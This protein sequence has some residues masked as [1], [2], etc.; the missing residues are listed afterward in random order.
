M[1]LYS[2]HGNQF[3]PATT[4]KDYADPLDTPFGD[5]IVTDLTR[6]I[7]P[8]GRISRSLDLR[9]VNKVF[10]VATIPEWVVGRFFYDLLGRVV[11]Y[12]LLPLIVG[13]ATYWVVEYLLT[14]THDGS[15]SSSFWGSYLTFPGL[16]TL[17]AEIARTRV[18]S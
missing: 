9:D 6:R 7:V 2:E 13:Y 17:L 3:D 11:T 18:Y 10:P 5:H 15:P 16:Q 14:V 12:L 8:A 1:V 4:I